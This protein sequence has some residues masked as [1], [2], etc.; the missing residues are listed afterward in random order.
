MEIVGTFLKEEVSGDVRRSGEEIHVPRK[1]KTSCSDYL[2]VIQRLTDL[3]SKFYSRISN[4]NNSLI[5]R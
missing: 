3:L 5:A 1:E 2:E 4:E